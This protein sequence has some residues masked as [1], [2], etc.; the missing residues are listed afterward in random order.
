MRLL[1]CSLSQQ[2]KKIKFF[3]SELGGSLRVGGLVRKITASG[4]L[5][6]GMG[7]V[8]NIMLYFIVFYFIIAEYG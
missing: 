7:L 3:G 1:F 5:V 6:S 4:I 8:V 2:D